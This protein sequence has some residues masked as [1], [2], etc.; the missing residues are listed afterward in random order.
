[1][2]L[3][4]GQ[5]C[6]TCGRRIEVRLELLGRSVACPHCHAEFIASERQTPQPSS[7]EALMD[8]VERA[9]RRSGAVVPV[10]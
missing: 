7:D 6:P 9:L 3:R 2:T 8:R 10:K 4:F 5:S 1:M